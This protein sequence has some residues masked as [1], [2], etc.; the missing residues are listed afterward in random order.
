MRKGAAFPS[1]FDLI[2]ERGSFCP[3]SQR[4]KIINIPT[5]QS[6]DLSIGG[7]HKPD[8]GIRHALLQMAR[9]AIGGPSHHPAGFIPETG[10]STG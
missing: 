4:K 1:G 8:V 10:P 3:W 6:N 5:H 9:L 7:L 2:Q